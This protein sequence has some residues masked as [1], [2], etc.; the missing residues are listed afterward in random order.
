MKARERHRAMKATAILLR[1]NKG[2]SEISQE[3]HIHP[4]TIYRWVHDLE[5][6]GIKLPRERFEDDPN[7]PDFLRR[8]NFINHE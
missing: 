7:L 8:D 5:K 6:A 2:V 4:R 3:L 1:Q